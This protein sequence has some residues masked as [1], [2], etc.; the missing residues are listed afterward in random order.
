MVPSAG[1]W[2]NK[3]CTNY[4]AHTTSLRRILRVFWPSSISNKDLLQQI[5]QDDMRRILKTWCWRWVE[6]VLR[7][8]STSITRT[9]MRWTPAGKQKRGRPRTAWHRTVEEELKQ[10]QVCWSTVEKTA[11]L[12]LEWTNLVAALCS[13]GRYGDE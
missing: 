1:G 10:H 9:A 5:N 12:R 6:H 4:P 7:K 8:N 3:T 11:K 13:R 2:Q